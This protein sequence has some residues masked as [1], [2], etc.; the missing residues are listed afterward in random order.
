MGGGGGLLA[1]E[2]PPPQEKLKTML[3]QNFGGDKQRVLWY[4]MVFSVKFVKT[5]LSRNYQKS[6][7]HKKTKP[8][9]EK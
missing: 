5:P 6:L 2:P 3:M 1:V 8:N 9:F 4:V 7:A